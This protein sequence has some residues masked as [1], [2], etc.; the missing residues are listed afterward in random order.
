MRLNDM[1]NRL[2]VLIAAVAGG[3]GAARAQEIVLLD[4]PFGDGEQIVYNVSY[5][6]ALIPPINMMRITIRTTEEQL[7]GRPHYHIVGNGRTTGAAKGVLELNDTYHSW[8]DT[9]TLLP[10]RTTSDIREN[11]YRLATTYTY[12][13]DAMSVSNVRNNPRWE[14]PRSA[15]FDLPGRQCGDAL[16]LLYRLRAMDVGRLAAGEGHKLDL[17]LSEDAKPVTLRYLGRETVRVRR[18][19]TFRALKFT[20]TMAT[21][22]GST[23]EEG[24]TL[25]AWV[26]DDENHI[27]LLLESPV[28][29]GRVSV[30]LADGYTTLHP[31]SSRVK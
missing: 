23:Y 26:S 30:T 24:M 18:L 13:W 31:L 21:S 4:A 29:I 1:M 2:F 6:A 5:R 28:R 14:A 22:D 9:E 10:S 19:G 3:L 17:V 15:T 27:P 25:T 11:D 20:C 16:S 8:L 12:D 7:D